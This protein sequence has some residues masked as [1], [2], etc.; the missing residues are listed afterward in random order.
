MK[1]IFDNLEIIIDNIKHL[2]NL[3]IYILVTIL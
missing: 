1:I 3:Y 2:F